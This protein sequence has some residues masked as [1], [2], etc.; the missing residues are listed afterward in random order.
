MG[1]RVV[2]SHL[3]PQKPTEN[4][5][6]QLSMEVIVMVVDSHY[7]DQA[8]RETPA[9]DAEILKQS[10]VKGHDDGRPGLL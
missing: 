8:R 3:N 6:H 1:R 10:G 2:S 9:E 5:S 4:L 7:I